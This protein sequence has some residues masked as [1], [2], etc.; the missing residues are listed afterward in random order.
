MFADI[1]APCD[2][3]R[4]GCNTAGYDGARHIIWQ[5]GWY[6]DDIPDGH[7]EYEDYYIGLA[8]TDPSGAVV[9]PFGCQ[10]VQNV[11]YLYSQDCWWGWQDGELYGLAATAG[12]DIHNP[13]QVRDRT[14]VLTSDMIPAGAEDDFESEFVLIEAFI[15]TGLAD[16]QA[17]IDDT[18]NILI[19]ELDELGIFDRDFPLPICGDANLDGNIDSGDILYLVNYLFLGTSAPRWPMECRADANHDG[20]VDLGDVV[21][22]INHLYLGAVAPPECPEHCYYPPPQ[23]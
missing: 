12:V 4:Y 23:G 7:P 6:N 17:H 1:N 5:H 21:Y 3:P 19:P 16:L 22:L 11:D 8:L 2:D 14:V 18:R 10:N 13:G 15:P 9:E 20:S